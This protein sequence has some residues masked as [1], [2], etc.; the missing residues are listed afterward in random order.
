VAERLIDLKDDSNMLLLIQGCKRNDRESQRLLYQHYY[1]F[2]MGICLRYCR[3]SDEAKEV[4]ND[5]FM[6]VF[7]K[8]DQ[9]N[10]DTSFHGWLKKILINTAIDQYRREKK[11]YNH[12]DLDSLNLHPRTPSIT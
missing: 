6:K 8:I 2:A 7:Q 4:L 12:A 10:Q 5:G 11:H 1:G 9:Y 3:T